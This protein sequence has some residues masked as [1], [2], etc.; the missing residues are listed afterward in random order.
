MLCFQHQDYDTRPVAAND[1]S[2]V[3]LSRPA[4][5]NSQYIGLISMANSGEDFTGRSGF[6]TGW[7]L[8]ESGERSVILQQAQI[9]VHTQAYCDGFYAGMMTPGQICLGNPGVAV[10]CSSDSGGPLIINGILAG[11]TSWGM[12]PCNADYPGVYESV[13]FHRE[14]IRQN[15]NV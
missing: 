13:A 9:S 8:D 10:S 6:I 5:L 14:W 4:N 2:L 3:R 1:V 12:S 7:G 11:L 15:I